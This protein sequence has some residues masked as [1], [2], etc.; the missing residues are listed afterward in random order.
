MPF[1]D[2]ACKEHGVMEVYRPM[3]EVSNPFPCPACSKTMQ[4]VW[5]RPLHF[6]DGIS[7]KCGNFTRNE[8]I[9]DKPAMGYTRKEL[10]DNMKKE[11]ME[12]LNPLNAGKTKLYPWGNE[13][14][15]H[16]RK[17]YGSR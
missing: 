6:S 17:A 16:L 12:P 1:Y 8:P 13:P 4:R 10:F 14:P 7:N 3:G 9:G 5:N 15:A 2:Y 11:D